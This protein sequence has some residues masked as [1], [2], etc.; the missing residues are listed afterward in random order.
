[1][2]LSL[3][4]IDHIASNYKYAYSAGYVDFYCPPKARASSYIAP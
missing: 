4:A 3:M 2:M 1:M